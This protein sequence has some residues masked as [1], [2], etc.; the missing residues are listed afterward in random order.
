LSRNWG[1]LGEM[2]LLLRTV[3][4]NRWFKA[5]AKPFL[6]NGDVPADCLGDMSTSENLLSV[7]EL[8]ENRSN[9]ER[10]VRAVVI[11]RNNI[12]NMGYIIFDSSVLAGVGIEILNN[13]GGSADSGAN[14]WHRDLRLSGNKMVALVKAI[15][16]SGEEAGQILAGC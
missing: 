14:V 8:E 6:A 7:W 12:E 16:E 3:K 11:G 15:L 9:L 4:Q 5:E 1:A 10:V 13:P 2:P